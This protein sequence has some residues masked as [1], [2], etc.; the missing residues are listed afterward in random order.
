MRKRPTIKDVAKAAGVSTATV[1]FVLN[2]RP[3]QV[4]SSRV[5]ARVWRVAE[6]LEYH[7]SASASGLARRRTNNVAVLFYQSAH[8]ISN[9]FYS[10]VIQGAIRE[11]TQREYNLIFS[12]VERD[13]RGST[14][15][16]KVVCEHNTEGVLA[17]Q[18]ISPEMIADIQ[19]RNIPVV[20]VDCYPVA[21]RVG[22]LQ[23]ENRRG[24]ELLAEHLVKLG[25]RRIML[26]SGRDEGR[27]SID[28]R[29]DGFLLAANARGV[30]LSRQDHLLHADHFSFGEGQRVGTALLTRKRRP[31]A[32]FCANDEMAAGLLR[33][34]R[35][36]GVSVPKELSVVGFDDITA[37]AFTDPPLTTVG[38]DKERLGSRAMARLIDC[39]ESGAHEPFSEDVG[40]DLVLR[41]STGPAG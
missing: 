30:P 27:P 11:A 31:T 18:R 26:I 5:K 38:G 39:I 20:A 16:P 1:S 34:A 19:S 23:M 29:V 9:L 33:A 3:G 14:D 13:Y 6:Q 40:M 21:P 24:G 12:Y 35:R 8:L 37:S 36:L 25:H 22:S 10:F 2:N 28:D 7:A 17:V 32:I 15:L 4:I 41:E